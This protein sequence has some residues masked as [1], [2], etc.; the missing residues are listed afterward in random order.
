ML[1]NNQQPCK[2]RSSSCP[3]PARR[4]GSAHQFIYPV[5][6]DRKLSSQKVTISIQIKSK[7]EKY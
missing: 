3:E 5:D 1:A 2:V 6:I 7:G 4:E